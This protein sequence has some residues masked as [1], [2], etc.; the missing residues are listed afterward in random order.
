MING[1]IELDLEQIIL[2]PSASFYRVKNS[3]GELSKTDI[4]NFFNQATNNKEIDP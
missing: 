2:A 1:K 3:S 4:N